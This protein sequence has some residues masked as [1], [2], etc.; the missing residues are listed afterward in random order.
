M[1]GFADIFSSG[2]SGGG[3]DSNGSSSSVGTTV[4]TGGFRFGNV[5]NSNPYVIGGVVIAIALVAV[6]ALRK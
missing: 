6:V 2:A 1:A 5:T 3:G 4:S